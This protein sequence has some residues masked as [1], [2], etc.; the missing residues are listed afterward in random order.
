MLTFSLLFERKEDLK[1]SVLGGFQNRFEINCVSGVP[2]L[3][4]PPTVA[5]IK[6]HKQKCFSARLIS[7]LF[8]AVSQTGRNIDTDSSRQGNSSRKLSPKQSWIFWAKYT[9]KDQKSSVCCLTDTDPITDSSQNSN[10]GRYNPSKEI[11]VTETACIFRPDYRC[12][13]TK[14]LFS[15]L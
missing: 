8:W 7:L 5:I 15:K 14:I 13:T 3:R 2:L 1:K 11:C 4:D 10:W 12:W 6:Q 9:L